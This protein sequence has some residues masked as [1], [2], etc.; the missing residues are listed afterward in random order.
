[1]GLLDRL[2]DVGRA[3]RN[4]FLPPKPVA[5]PTPPPPIRVPARPPRI[6]EIPP[7][8]IFLYEIEIY[9]RDKGKHLTS[10][11]DTALFELKSP[12][13]ALTNEEIELIFNTE[14]PELYAWPGSVKS[15]KITRIRRR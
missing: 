7:K 1:M 4:V 5:P 3:I 15:V 13:E 10:E 2:R 8:P 12:N 11:W 6:E 9:T 14:N